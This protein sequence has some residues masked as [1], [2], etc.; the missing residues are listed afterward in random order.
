[1]PSE[2]IKQAYQLLENCTVCPRSCRVNRFIAPEGF[3]HSGIK[4]RISS[5][6]L[7]HGE[8]PPISGVP[9]AAARRGSGT[10]FFSSCNMACQYC[11]NYQISQERMGHE[12]SEEQLAQEMLKLER[13]GAHNINLVSPSHYGPQILKALVIAKEKGLKIPIVYNSNGYDGIEMLQFLRGHVDIYMPD[14]KYGYG[15]NAAKYSNAPR[16]VEASHQA[17]AE[18]FHQVGPLKTDENGVAKRG[19]LVRHLVLPNRIAGSF[20]V[21]K[22]V[23][24]LSTEVFLSLMSQYYPTHCAPNLPELNRQIT[25]EEYQE[26]VDYALK[27][28]FENLLIQDLASHKTYRPDFKKKEVF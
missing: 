3:C 19:L 12:I 26:V 7:H 18:M 2:Q 22:F 11:Q 17:V 21:L 23:A 14:I 5:A 20:D 15:K 8:E 13:K 25:R 1:M 4:M 28:G 6:L 27:L 10:I 24:S 16:Y 9:G